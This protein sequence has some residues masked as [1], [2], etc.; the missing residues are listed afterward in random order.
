[1]LPLALYSS[2]RHFIKSFPFDSRSLSFEFLNT[3]AL[4]EITITPKNKRTE[5]ITI[6]ENLNSL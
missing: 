4:A 6:N 1:M 3:L 5:I 2:S